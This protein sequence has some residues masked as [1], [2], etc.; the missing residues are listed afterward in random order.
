MTRMVQRT[1]RLGFGLLVAILLACGLVARIAPLFN[2]D[3][4]PARQF[5]TEDAY[6]ML[7]IARN[8]AI[9]NG[10]STAAGTIPTNGT[11][12]AITFLWAL[13]YRLMNGDKML[14]V[15]VVQVLE[16]AIG[17]TGASHLFLAEFYQ[18]QRG[19][20]SRRHRLPG[21]HGDLPAGA[22]LVCW[23]WLLVAT[24]GS[25]CRAI[26]VNAGTRGQSPPQPLERDTA[27]FTR[28]R[29]QAQGPAHPPLALS[30]AL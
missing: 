18:K 21:P 7:T 11:Q 24:G 16:I 12:P 14:G 6:L 4:R 13:G 27:G 25:H 15:A 8:M 2:Q 19:K 29:Q 20:E 1:R 28:D 5:P 26:S 3:D 30:I 9:G 22:D 10:M 17:L 23:R